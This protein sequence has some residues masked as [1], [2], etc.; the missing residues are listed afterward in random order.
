MLIITL[1]I[2]P[3]MVSAEWEQCQASADEFFAK[4]LAKSTLKSY[5][6]GIRRYKSFCVRLSR[7]TLP[8]REETLS[9]F[10]AALA[11]KGVSYTSLKVYLSAIRHYQIQNGLGDPGISR[12]ARL[13]YIM[14]GIRRDGAL[15]PN[16]RK[17]RQPITPTLLSKLFAVWER[18]TDLRNAK[19]LWAASCLAFFAFLRVG[20]FTAS[21]VSQ[22][23]DKVHLSISDISI[24]RLEAPSMALINLKQS[25]TD[26]LR[27]GVTV[28]L[29]KT[30][31][32]PL[33]PV[34]ALLS[35]LVVRGT[36]PGP[37]FIWENGQFLT[38]A[39][40]VEEVKKALQLAGA[41]ASD[42]NGHSFRIGAA[43][44]AAAN[45]ME[46]SLIKILG[47]WESDAY[48]RYIK[49][50]RQELANYTLL[51]SS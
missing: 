18:Q 10:V 33:C 8:A 32:S 24:N 3:S 22:F 5:Q 14:R 23:D 41:D 51:L 40:F 46:D 7:P 28:V 38:R 12:M 34:S 36:A 13:E 30:N 1:N 15:K 42:F 49:I 11:K 39:H 50:P 25:K 27:K 9:A 4:G 2:G 31:K 21:G 16:P 45:G 43:S 37:V 6:S 35:Y 19:M 26:Q 44:T 47:R 20:E 29:G 48:Q 17:E